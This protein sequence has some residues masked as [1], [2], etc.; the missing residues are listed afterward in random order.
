MKKSVIIGIS[1]GSGS[2]KTTFIKTLSQNFDLVSLCVISQDEYYFPRD[3]QLIDDQGIHNF[4]LPSAIDIQAFLRDI[5][6]LMEGETVIKKEYT[7]NNELVEPKIIELKP[8][9]VIIVEG[10]FIFQNE[11]LREL[12]DYT[13]IINAKD[14]DK[15]IRRI[16]RDKTE[17]NYPIEDVLYRYKNHVIPAYEK[18]IEP[19]LS[20]VDIIV[21]N[22]ETFEKGAE[23]LKHFISSISKE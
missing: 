6:K 8:A 12:L 11:E 22:N 18:Y 9:K 1:G 13:I 15:I 7:F 5:K 16:L 3:T 21:N 17:R 10:L 23:I 14:S 4:D 20:E 2:G 19:Y